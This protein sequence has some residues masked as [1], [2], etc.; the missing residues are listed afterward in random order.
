MIRS[1][2][3]AGIA[4]VLCIVCVAPR[5]APAATTASPS[6]KGHWINVADDE[7]YDKTK[8]LTHVK[9]LTRIFDPEKEKGIAPPEDGSVPD[10]YG[11]QLLEAYKI[12]PEDFQKHLC[13]LS[14]IYVNDSGCNPTCFNTSWGLRRKLENGLIGR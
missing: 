4:M 10:S 2:L 3:G 13:N 9:L 11:N 14:R 7:C 8:F 5:I 1:T 12:A 6:G